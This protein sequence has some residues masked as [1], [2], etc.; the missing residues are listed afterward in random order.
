MT[1]NAESVTSGLLDG[2]KEN[3]SLAVTIGIVLI[4]A[5]MLALVSPLVAGLSITIMVGAT[6]AIGGIGQCFFAF[7]AGAFGRGLTMFIWGVLMTIA[8]VYMMTQPAAGLASITLFLAAY[9]VIAGLFELIAAFQ[10]KPADG[11]GLTLFNG[12]VTLVLGIMLWRQ[13]PLSG[14]WAVGVLFGIK[15]VFSGWTLVFIGRS[16]K[17][18]AGSAQAST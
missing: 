2:I 6:L 5:G 10:I 9:F 15:M 3:A 18:T 4:I 1:K 14:T 17:Q 11:W 8:G 7:K 13:F 12:I 16:V